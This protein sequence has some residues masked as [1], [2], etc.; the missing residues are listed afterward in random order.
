MILLADGGSSKVDWRLI[1]TQSEI[2][3]IVTNGLNPFI[4]TE[5]EI[6]NEIKQ[7]LVAELGGYE[8]T[9]VYFY[10][11][12]C[13]FVDKNEM[14]KRAIGAHFPKAY[15]EINSDLLAVARGLCGTEEGIACILGTGSNSCYYDGTN[16]I[17]N[18]SPLGYVLG[19]EGSGAVLGRL[20][21][22]ACLKN[23][24]TFGLKEELLTEF[25]LSIAEILDRV[26]KQPMPN[27]FLASFA[28]FI[29]KKIDDPSIYNLVYNSFKAFY[30]KNVMQY[31]Y[32]NTVTH[33][34]GSIAFYFQDILK[35]LAK[36]LDI[37]LGTIVQSPMEGLI[38]YHQGK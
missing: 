11:A 5:E 34:S 8:V 4:R 21:L 38:T 13:A 2:K 20:F 33:L 27:K 15:I 16:I 17:N 1:D 9:D 31:P 35:D 30:V 14:I 32:R 37:H 12:G 23:Q 3:K 19:D 7:T 10:G 25:D 18:V 22:S 26:Y 28:P 36:S 29:L 6:S 24:L